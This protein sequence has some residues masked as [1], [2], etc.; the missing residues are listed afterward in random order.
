MDFYMY[1]CC[2]YWIHKKIVEIAWRRSR[3]CLN[4]PTL[5]V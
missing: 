3:N 1:L 2:T 4:D 5:I